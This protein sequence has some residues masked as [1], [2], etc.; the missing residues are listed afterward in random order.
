VAA[1]ILWGVTTCV[2]KFSVLTFYLDIFENR[3]FKRCVYVVMVV[4]ALLF[5][6]VILG[7]CLLCTPFR[8]A[9]DK[10]IVGGHC[11]DSTKNYLAVGIV[12]M[13]I[14]FAIVGLPMPIL[15]GL[16]MPTNKKIA[17]STILALGLL[18]V[19]DLHH[20]YNITDNLL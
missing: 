20:L 12:N 19:R 18:Y 6:A 8:Y 15:W 2:I 3:L 7:T 1:P 17:I 4:T 5:C 11:A 10:T 16:Q 13:I 9:W 14:D